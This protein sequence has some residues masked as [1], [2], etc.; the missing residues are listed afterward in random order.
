MLWDNALCILPGTAVVVRHRCPAVRIALAP[1]LID[2]VDFSG[3]VAINLVSLRL[4]VVLWK[5]PRFQSMEQDGSRRICWIA[6]IND[7]DI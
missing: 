2:F 4:L 5:P 3:G 6:H 1:E 7:N